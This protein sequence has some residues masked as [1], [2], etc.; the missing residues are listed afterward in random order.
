MSIRE[1]KIFD[2]VFSNRELIQGRALRAILWSLLASLSL[3]VMLVLAFWTIDLCLVAG[4]GQPIRISVE[5]YH[6]FFGTGSK[7]AVEVAGKYELPA[8]FAQ[9][10]WR[11]RNRPWGKAA[12]FLARKLFG[13]EYGLPPQIASLIL[14]LAAGVCWIITWICLRLARRERIKLELEAVS[15]LRSHI[16]RQALRLGPAD[17]Q[18]TETN[19][20][21]S[22]FKDDLNQLRGTL[23]LWLAAW[24]TEPIRV[25]LLVA[26]C[27]II[28]AKVSFYCGVPLLFGWLIYEHRRREL[29]E[30]QRRVAVLAQDQLRLLAESLTR[31]RLVRGYGMEQPAQDHFKKYMDRYRTDVG[32]LERRRGVMSRLQ[33]IFVWACGIIVMVLLGISLTTPGER[34]SLASASVLLYCFDGIAR[35]IRNWQN[36][37]E[38]RDESVPAA[39]R[40]FRYLDRIPEV[41]QAVGAKFLNPLSRSIDF[42]NVTYAAPDKTVLLDHLTLSIPASR[43]IALISTDGHSALALASLLPR[44]IDPQQGD[45]R[46]DGEDIAWVTLESLRAEIVFAGGTDMIFTGTVQENISAGDARYGVAEIMDAAKTAHVQSFIQHL[47]QGYETLVG[48]H[49]EAL[50]VGQAFRL[51]LAR[52]FLRDPALLIIEEPTEHLDDDTKALIDDAYQRMAPNRTV[53]YLPNRLSTLR[54]CDE[55]ILL[56]QGKVAARGTYDQLMTSS[57]LYMHWEYVRFN[58]FR[59]IVDGQA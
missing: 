46:I 7:Y 34:F 55:I 31:S 18:R 32:K 49:G 19:Q 11:S 1:P 56:H 59:H 8:S 38:A 3:V 27:L 9:V 45:V 39:M 58:V 33:G 10:A 12:S 4:E 30:A 40:V 52:G 29:I 20:L 17:L 21:L 44:F 16:H 53:I 25:A 14:I 28:D 48:E 50:N 5:D 54:R 37:F 47:P 23:S 42:N 43:Q 41:G 26:L 6:K 13:I 2:R 36:A 35:S 15:H 51:A 57:R 22:M 24:T